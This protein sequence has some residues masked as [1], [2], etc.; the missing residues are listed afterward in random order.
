MVCKIPL[1]KIIGCDRQGQFSNAYQSEGF[2]PNQAPLDLPLLKSTE[3]FLQ[4]LTALMDSSTQQVPVVNEDGVF[5]GV[6]SEQ[7]IAAL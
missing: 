3:S 1:T 2:S 4:G 5:K 7:A 6:F